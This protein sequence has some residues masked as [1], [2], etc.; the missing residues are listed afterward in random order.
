MI[1]AKEA[2]KTK[3]LVKGGL[4][5]DLR[6]IEVS[7]LRLEVAR[8]RARN[9]ILEDRVTL[10]ARGNADRQRRFRERKRARG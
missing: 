9:V 5:E 7:A 1:R 8:L 3:T 2:E 6:L 10:L 4:G